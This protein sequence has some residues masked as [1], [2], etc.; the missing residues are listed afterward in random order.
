MV[1]GYNSVMED[2]GVFKLWY[3]AIAS[4]GS[5][6]T[7]YAISQDGAHWDKLN[8]GIVPFGGN[9]DTNIVFPPQN[10]THEPNCVF[11]DT[12][13][14]CRPEEKFKMVASLHPP[15]TAKRPGRHVARRRSRVD[16]VA[17]IACGGVPC[18]VVRQ[19]NDWRQGPGA[20]R[21]AEG[22]MPDRQT[23]PF[24]LWIITQTEGLLA[25]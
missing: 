14:A 19:N 24:A 10:M 1:N 18:A 2:E 15:D 11:K 8:V 25:P 12:N 16:P 17:I 21:R 20:A 9:E 13:P 7:C 4:D 23:E 22:L 5:R 3:D 6:W